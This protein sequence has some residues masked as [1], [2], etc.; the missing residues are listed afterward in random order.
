MLD[1]GESAGRRLV[2]RLQVA[3]LELAPLRLGNLNFPH[4]FPEGYAP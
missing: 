2:A 3:R 4:D 1:A